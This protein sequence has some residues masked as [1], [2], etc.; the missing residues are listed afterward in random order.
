M[1]VA[2]KT[3]VLQSVGLSQQHFEDGDAAHVLFCLLTQCHVSTAPALL[4]SAGHFC[5]S[6]SLIFL[7]S[8]V[9][10]HNSVY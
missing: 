3:K 8:L 2:L 4:L 1:E 6:S 5:S 9:A 7:R 10:V